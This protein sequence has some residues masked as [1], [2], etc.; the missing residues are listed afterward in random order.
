MEEFLKLGTFKTECMKIQGGP[1][2]PALPTPMARSFQHF[3]QLVGE[4][5]LI[6]YFLAQRAEIFVA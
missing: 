4:V 2:P 5:E 3:K 1:C 6:L